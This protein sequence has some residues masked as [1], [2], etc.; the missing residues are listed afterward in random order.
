MATYIKANDVYTFYTQ[1][2]SGLLNIGTAFQEVI[3]ITTPSLAEGKYV[4]GYA[5]ELNFDSQKNQ[6]AIF[7]LTGTFGSATEFSS[8]IGDNDVGLK[9]RAYWFPKDW[10]GGPITVG[11][12]FKKSASF[13]A[14]LDVNFVDVVVRYVGRIDGA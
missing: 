4:I 11:I 7:Q 1:K 9:N 14:Q 3:T 2:E 10:A 12:N 5:F 8:S 6:P 13:S